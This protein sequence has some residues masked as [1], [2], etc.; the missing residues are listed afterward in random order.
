MFREY[1]LEGTMTIYRGGGT[2]RYFK[3][4]KNGFI[5]TWGAGLYFHKFYDGAEMYGKVEEYKFKGDMLDPEYDG[6]LPK[7]QFLQ[8]I[9]ALNLELEFNSSDRFWTQ[10]QKIV[11]FGV[12][13]KMTYKKIFEVI[14]KYSGIS[15]WETRSEVVVFLERD[16]KKV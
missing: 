12:K 16:V 9:D 15:G 11:T 2:P 14:K 3:P 5:G 10:V 6:G 7:K 4:D 13:R 1:L 8:I